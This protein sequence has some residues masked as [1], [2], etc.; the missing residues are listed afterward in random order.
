MDQNHEKEFTE[1]T[2][3]RFSEFYQATYSKLVTHITKY[4]NDTWKA[5]DIAQDAF[6]QALLRISTYRSVSEG[7]ATLSTWLFS[8]AFHRWLQ[9]KNRMKDIDHE[10][11]DTYTDK[12]M[13]SL[14]LSMERIEGE[15]AGMN[16]A[17]ELKAKI[18]IETIAS[19]PSKYS[20][21]KRALELRE[22]RRMPY[23]QI[24]DESNQNLSTVKSQVR[25][26][27]AIV[28][29]KVALKLAMIE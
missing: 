16:I 10:S 5:Q 24:A 2:G 11:M 19:M 6:L 8:I 9:I 12:Q 15:D 4:T 18:I 3:I 20:K 28:R 7:G 23:Q 13:N 26:G 21:I 27:R 14:R 22:L 17:N 25:K 1:R 29:K